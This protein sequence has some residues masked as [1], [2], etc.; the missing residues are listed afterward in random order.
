MIQ[1]YL[2]PFESDSC[3]GGGCGVGLTRA[4]A[5]A[6]DLLCKSPDD[7]P[8]AGNVVGR[9]PGRGHREPDH[10]FAL[11]RSGDCVQLT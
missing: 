3:P 8:V 1:V 4:A 2:V 11:Q 7:L 9:G 5:A 6:H 10:V